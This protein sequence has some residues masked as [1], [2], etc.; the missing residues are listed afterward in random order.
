MVSIKT[1]K[2][3]FPFKNKIITNE[4]IKIKKDLWDN[5][6]KK[7][8]QFKKQIIKIIKTINVKKQ[9]KRRIKERIIN[10]KLIK[11]LEIN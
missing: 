1:D 11:C 3:D 7:T 9:R 2:K 10:L 4:I 5:F 8:H 6:A